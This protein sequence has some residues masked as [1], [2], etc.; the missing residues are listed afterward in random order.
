MNHKRRHKPDL[1]SL[2]VIVVA[3]AMSV[4][5]AYQ[6][7]VYYGAQAVPIA[8]QTPSGRVGG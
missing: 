5:V 1:F 3:I 7:N 6:V 8:E 2:V 4:T